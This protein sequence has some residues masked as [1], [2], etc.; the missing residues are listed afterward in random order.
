[1]IKATKLIT[2]KNLLLITLL[3]VPL[4]SCEV[5]DASTVNQ[6]RIYTGYELSYIADEDKTIAKAIFRFGNAAG[7]QLQLSED[8]TITFNDQAIPFN[9]FLGN[10]E[11][12]LSGLVSSGTFA[13][14][15]VDGNTFTN[16]FS[17]NPIAL[18]SEAPALI[19][20]T[21]SYDI[22]WTGEPVGS[23]ESAV[24]VTVIPNNLGQTK[25]FIE[26]DEGA[27]SVV[28]TPNILKEI[29]PQPAALVIE[30]RDVLTDIE[31]PSAG[32][33]FNGNYR[34]ASLEVTLE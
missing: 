17:I 10:Y 33:F 30:R 1:M 7:T 26:G 2:M 11:L 18:T 29:D 32:G 14:E 25:I 34:A 6:D 13:Y 15:D 28:L 19:D 21:Q 24:V 27:T 12:E 9:N 3:V 20:R 4:L 8:A 22:D 16:T 23:G 31:A 5:E